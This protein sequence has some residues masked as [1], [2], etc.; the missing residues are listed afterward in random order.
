MS[1]IAAAQTHAGEPSHPGGDTAAARKQRP[2][3]DLP[4]SLTA[5]RNRDLEGQA[6]RPWYRR[7]LML[8]VSALPILALTNLFGQK[9]TTSHANSSRARL[10]VDA[11]ERL[12]GGLIYQARIEVKALTD[13]RHAQ[14]V[15]DS[16]WWDGMSVNSIEP[17]PSN[18][19]SQNGGVSLSYGH[20]G[21]GQKLIVWIYYQ[22]NPTT[23]GH[24]DQTAELDDGTTLLA[25]IPRK[26]TIFP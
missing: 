15:L 17:Q 5:S 24:H 20:L 6:R 14:L 11:P 22:T 21:A 23:V 26:V 8:L 18:E 13:I 7:S 4:G 2:M 19:G 16:G 1:R 25:R 9:P 10:T 12:R 3:A